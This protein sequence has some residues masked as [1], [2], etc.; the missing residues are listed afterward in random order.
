MLGQPGAS[1]QTRQGVF[2]P[3]P[4]ARANSRAVPNKG[5][6]GAVNETGQLLLG[7]SGKGQRMHRWRTTAGR[8]GS[9]AA[10]AAATAD[11]VEI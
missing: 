4:E 3:S 1:K 9:A 8:A 11:R 7:E 10:K 5:T 6:C 2:V